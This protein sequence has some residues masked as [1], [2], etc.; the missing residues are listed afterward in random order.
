MGSGTKHTIL[1]DCKFVE[2]RLVHTLLKKN[3]FFQASLQ[4]F[5]FVLCLLFRGNNGFFKI[6]RGSDHCGIESEISAGIPAN[7]K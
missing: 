2:Y 1:A 7:A 5:K 6:L 3:V 4:V